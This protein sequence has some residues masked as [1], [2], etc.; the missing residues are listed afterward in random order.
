[1]VNTA[2]TIDLCT[3]INQDFN[4]DDLA[5]AMGISKGPYMMF[6]NITRG[7]ST[8]LAEQLL[9]G[10]MYQ[11]ESSAALATYSYRFIA[12]EEGQIL[13]AVFSNPDITR[14]GRGQTPDPI[15]LGNRVVV[16]VKSF[17][18]VITARIHDMGSYR[19]FLYSLYHTEK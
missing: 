8:M 10:V 2:A 7:T 1:M 11:T 12:G 6:K 5:I 9:G 16:F 4:A 3:A 14:V 15:K 18:G 17:Y 19:E 13:M